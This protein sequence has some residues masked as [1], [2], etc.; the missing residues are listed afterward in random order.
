MLTARD[1][2]G[3]AVQKLLS[4]PRVWGGD[5]DHSGTPDV[6]TLRVIARVIGEVIEQ[7]RT[8]VAAW[9]DRDADNDWYDDVR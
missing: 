1:M 6:E 8:Q 9:N 4:H 7:D 2:G 3:L 5:P